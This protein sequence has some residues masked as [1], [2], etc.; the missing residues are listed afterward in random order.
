MN[1]L[2]LARW[3][4]AFTTAF[5]FLIVPLTI[6]LSIFVAL[7]ETRYVRSGDAIYKRMA[8]FWGKIFVV[9]FAVGV[10]SGLVLEFQFGMNWSNYAR[11]MGDI[12]GAPLAIEAM[13]AFFLE[14]TFL[15]LWIFGWE[16]LSKKLHLACM[17]LVVAGSLLS[18]LWILTANSFMHEPVGYALQD[19]RVVMTDFFALTTNPHLFFQFAHIIAA[20]FTTGAFFILGVSAY[21]LLRG[22]SEAFTQAFRF[23][24]IYG[25]A[26]TL[27]VIGLGHAQGQHLMDVQPMK[28]AAAEALWETEQPAAFSVV[29]WIDEEA[30]ENSFAIRIPYVLSFLTRNSFT[31]EVKGINELQAYYDGLYGSDDYIPPVTLIFWSFRLMVGAGTALLGLS[32]LAVLISVVKRKSPWRWLLKVLP[33]AIALPYLANTTGWIMTETGRQPWAVFG[34]LKTKHAV[35]PNVTGGEVFFSL[36][37]FIVI[38]TLLLGADGYLMVKHI[39]AG[40][41][42]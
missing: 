5:H 18:A 36:L 37:G 14:S 22:P 11:F 30:G 20:C 41:R 3:Q 13:V 12:F 35:S 39:K 27:L 16:R 4:F 6:G 26:G 23:G 10:V 21:H 15:G 7:L 33:F 24:A 1:P 2:A 28:M 32:G 31:A 19:K 42:E 34:L 38:Y 29:A 8:K 9:N 17:W 40:I 25:I